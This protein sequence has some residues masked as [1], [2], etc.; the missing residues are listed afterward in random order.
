MAYSTQSAVSDG[1]LSV[2]PLSIDYLSR[3]D[4]TVYIG[5]AQAVKDVAWS[6]VGTIDRS[7]KFT[8]TVPKDV[9]VTIKRSTGVTGLY[10]KFAGGAQFTSKTLDE[11]LTQTLF[12]AQEFSE[13]SSVASDDLPLPVGSQASAGKSNKY[14]RTDHVHVGMTGGS[15]GSVAFDSFVGDGVKLSFALANTPTTKGATQV[16]VDNVYQSK[17]AYSLASNVLTFD[18]APAVG[19]VIEVI[20]VTIGGGRASDVQFSE[21]PELPNT[22]T[23]GNVQGVLAWLGIKRTEGVVSVK[24]YGAKG[25]GTADDTAAINSAVAAAI[26]KKAKLVFPADT[27]KV[28]GPITIRASGLRISGESSVI[29]LASST[30]GFVIA[31]SYNKL[32]D[33]VFTQ[34]DQSYTPTAVTLL[35]DATTVLSIHNKVQGCRGMDVY[36][37]VLV[38]MT[39][40]G[41]GKA[42]YRAAIENCEFIN[43][44][45]QKTWAGSF[46]I[47]FDGP[48]SGDA[49]G[50]DSKAVACVVAGYE[51]NYVVN[52]S[53]ATQLIGCSGDGGAVCISYEGGASAL[54]VVGGYYEYNDT[55]LGIVGGL[56]YDA[57]ILYPSY[58]NNTNYMTGAGVS[59]VSGGLPVGGYGTVLRNGFLSGDAS[60]G[61]AELDPANGFK[62]YTANTRTLRMSIDGTGDWTFQNGRML[63]ANMALYTD[64]VQGYN[65]GSTP[66]DLNAANK[67]TLTTAN[68]VQFTVNN[69]GDLVQGSGG[70]VITGAGHIGLKAYNVGT[71][72]S[73]AAAAQMIYVNGSATGKKLA[74]S[75]GTNWRWADG[76]V[77]S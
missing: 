23:G 28:S 40:N 64:K 32:V 33:F 29:S 5:S 24:D 62:L 11:S 46:G 22:S 17:Q 72:P 20:T 61:K 65:G 21:T 27:Y 37:G 8:P 58:A 76:T 6:W 38:N 12:V 43:K 55:F 25:G 71:L 35:N 34:A 52:N 7:I 59:F 31:G 42:C 19:A 30:A 53:V 16:Y 50:N 63:L 2:L 66:L 60:T 69:A 4:I 47:A 44:Y 74:I 45:Q 67:I 26:A 77:V 39:V 1:T 48:N 3:D 18:E 15:V 68:T 73:A 49:G 41:A 54:Q 70:T 10:H 36:R 57:Y 75:D 9:V 14:A 56:K 13:S 51:R